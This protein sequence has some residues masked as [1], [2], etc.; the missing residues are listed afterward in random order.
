MGVQN[1]STTPASNTLISGINIGEGCA[2]SG[3]NDAIRQL[4]AD[5]ATDVPN[6]NAVSTYTAAQNWA[7]G[8]DIASA[9]TTDIGAATGNFVNVTGTTTITGLGTVAAGAVRWVRFTGALTLTHNGTSLIL[10]GGVNITTANGDVAEFISLGSGNWLCANYVP[11]SGVPALCAP[12]ASPSFTGTPSLPIGTTG[13]TQSPGDNS[14]KIATTGF[15]A[16]LG[17]LKAALAGDQAQSFSAADGAS[18]KQVV[19]ISQFATSLSTNGYAKLPGGLILQWGTSGNVPALG[20]L[21]VTLPLTFPNACLNVSATTL[22]NSSGN[23]GPMA[24]QVVSTSQI[25]LC[26]YNNGSNNVPA[27]WIALGY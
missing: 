22:C 27:Y 6:K 10:P 21:N 9:T 5:V 24:A 17:A 2:P 8:A 4:M 16:A 23:W 13:V 18:G 14:A 3:I 19:N 7:L 12:I 15:V 20:T 25:V 26:R 1:Y 11:A